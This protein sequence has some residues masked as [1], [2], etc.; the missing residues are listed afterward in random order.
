MN[1]LLFCYKR[2]NQTVLKKNAAFSSLFTG[3]KFISFQNIDPK[4]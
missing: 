3:K 4:N 1:V 2:N